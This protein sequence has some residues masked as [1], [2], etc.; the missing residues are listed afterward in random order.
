M[1]LIRV[2]IHN[3]N[4]KGLLHERMNQLQKLE[5]TIFNIVSKIGT[6]KCRTLGYTKKAINQYLYDSS[7]EVTDVVKIKIIERFKKGEIYSSKEVK[8]YI[9]DVYN[10][11]KLKKKAKA[12]DIS[13]YISVN[14]S[15]RYINGVK[16]DSVLVK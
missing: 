2:A 5:P 10:N 11:L 12:T 14:K 4:G 8:E 1:H 9:Q 7:P 13:E 6:S 3:K 16:T 15:K